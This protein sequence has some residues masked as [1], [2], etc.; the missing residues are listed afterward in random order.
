MDGQQFHQYQQ[1]ERRLSLISNHCTQSKKTATYHMLFIVK[2][3]TYILFIF[4][5]SFEH[6]IT[7]EESVDV[8]SPVLESHF[9]FNTSPEEFWEI[10][11]YLKMRNLL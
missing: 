2:I 9:L 6:S 7:I 11:Q 1:N 10:Y 8:L 4:S 5:I 3:F